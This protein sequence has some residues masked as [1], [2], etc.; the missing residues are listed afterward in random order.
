MDRCCDIQAENQSKSNITLMARSV[1]PHLFRV[2]LKSIS[3]MAGS[4]PG[5]QF[6]ACCV[7]FTYTR[8]VLERGPSLLMGCN[9]ALGKGR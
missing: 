9:Q 2:L 3:G 4:L 6:S 7:Y 8:G 1:G 5:D